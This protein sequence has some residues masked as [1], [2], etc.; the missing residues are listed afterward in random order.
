MKKVFDASTVSRLTPN[1]SYPIDLNHLFS[2]ESIHKL[3]PVYAHQYTNCLYLRD[4]FY[5]TSPLKSN[6]KLTHHP[7]DQPRQITR[8]KRH[9]L[10]FL[11]RRQI[12]KG[13]YFIA[14]DSW[15]T[16]YFHWL[17]DAL[18]RIIAFQEFVNKNTILILP[19]SVRNIDYIQDSL[20]ILGIRHLIA[21]QSRAYIIDSLDFIDPIT[22]TGNYN[23]LCIRLLRQRFRHNQK[24]ILEK[25]TKTATKLTDRDILYV[26][27]AQSS[28]RHL[29]NE[30]ELIK[31]IGSVFNIKVIYPENF[32]FTE[33]LQLFS[34][35][36]LL[37][38]LHGAGLSNMLFMNQNSAVLE[39]RVKEDA[40]NNCFS[41]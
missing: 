17:L 28:R 35:A 32:N 41:P 9:L 7:T 33:Q 38:G 1:H 30:Q 22:S 3:P 11:T 20:H 29:I 37:V 21:S 34:K 15:L 25:P 40:H 14:T 24:I 12:L 27:R 4:T 23:P 5:T 2:S 31:A 39:I 10:R 18:P 19:A 16:G 26:S 36:Y 6:F 13:R 8:L